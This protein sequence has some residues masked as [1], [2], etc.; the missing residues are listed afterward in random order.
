MCAGHSIC[1]THNW[2]LLSLD[3][4]KE[5][6]AELANVVYLM[7]CVKYT[8]QVSI[9]SVKPSR[10]HRPR[11]SRFFFLTIDTPCRIF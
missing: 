3:I 2:K 4:H 6:P 11:F 10:F 1:P 8:D 5:S 7:H 9:S